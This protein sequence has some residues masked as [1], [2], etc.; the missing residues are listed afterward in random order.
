MNVNFQTSIKWTG[1]K[2]LQALLTEYGLSLKELRYIRNSD[3]R[4]ISGLTHMG[5]QHLLV[6]LATLAGGKTSAK[7]KRGIKSDIALVYKPLGEYTRMMLAKL[8]PMDKQGTRAINKLQRGDATEYRK[9]GKMRGWKLYSLSTNLDTTLLDKIEDM[10]IQQKKKLRYRKKLVKTQQINA[11]IKERIQRWGVIG[12]Y[13]YD[14]AR[15]LGHNAQ[16]VRGLS[17]KKMTPPA[18]RK[19]GEGVHISTQNAGDTGFMINIT[20]N[21][22]YLNQTRM[23]DLFRVLMYWERFYARWVETRLIA[24]ASVGKLKMR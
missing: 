20:V 15:K 23:K 3:P 17:R 22:R 4:S 11:T 18:K 6:K 13:F 8:S 19:E 5:G 1:T 21:H 10:F 24:Y 9:I 7:V 2:G 12:Y 14:A 16:T